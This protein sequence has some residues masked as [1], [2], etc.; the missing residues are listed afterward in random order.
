MQDILAA[1]FSVRTCPPVI[2]GYFF[3][4]N[5]LSVLLRTAPS[6]RHL[7]HEFRHRLVVGHL[8]GNDE[9]VLAHRHPEILEL[10]AQ[11]LREIA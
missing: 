6:G 1:R 8:D 7:Q 4:V 5:A 11:R 3:S 9:V 10:A 2:A